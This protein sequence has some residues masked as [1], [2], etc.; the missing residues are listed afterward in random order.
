[1]SD[2]KKQ[3]H[4]ESY[5]SGAIIIKNYTDSLPEK[6]GVY[7]MI[8]I[9][10]KVLYVGKAKNLKARVLSY[11]RSTSLNNRIM[12][13]VSQ[14][15]SMIFERTASEAAAFLLEADLIKSLKPHFN[16]LLKDD[17]SYPY[18]L[19]RKDHEAPQILKHRGKKITKGIYW[20]PFASGGN[21]NRILETLQKV[22][23]LRTCTD[24]VYENRSR[25]CLLYQIKRCSAP[26]TGEI[27]LPEYEKTVQYAIDFMENGSKKII[28]SLTDDMY[29]ASENMDYEKAAEYR[30]RLKALSQIGLSSDFNP[31]TFSEADIFALFRQDGIVCIQANFM[32]SGQNWGGNAYFPKFQEDMTNS[33]IMDGFLGQFYQNKP[34]AK[35]ILISDA[36]SETDILIQALINR[37]DVK[38]SIEI[39]QKGEKKEAVNRIMLTAE[40]ELKRKIIDTGTQ[41]ELMQNL[42][43]MLDIDEKLTR[44]E[45][46]DNAH[47]Q[48]A[49]AVG[50]M[51][52]ATAE[53][54]A[55]KEYRTWKM[56]DINTQTNDDYAMM[57]EVFTRRFK[58]LQNE[59]LE[60]P[61]NVPSLII[62]DGGQGQL[63]TVLQVAN[64][65]NIIVPI[66]AVAKGQDR[67]AGRERFFLPNKPSF[68]LPPND[69]ILFYVQRLRDEAHRYANGMHQRKRDKPTESNEL[70]AITGIGA[71]RKKALI[72]H[73]GSSRAVREAT[74]EQLEKTPSIS[75]AIAQKIYAYFNDELD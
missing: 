6:P 13:M 29:Q 8:D 49:Y 50:A 39:P 4:S 37:Y 19:C 67:N 56:K 63:S 43:D 74:L 41:T 7:R 57:R 9:N 31:T 46:Y 27:S 52:V 16:V 1:M 12:R 75:K 64:L 51:I 68:I 72:A 33:D 73:F 34:P 69:K 59:S 14:T 21:V 10:N 70:D 38:V 11:T 48:G 45:V 17:K 18:I 58:S 71:G 47:I 23:L 66:I 36:I 3:F 30:D 61:Q 20:G 44:I 22:F 26:C 2:E 60:N 62:L 24:S 65:Y 25:P 5:E 55:K 28:K 42:A 35:L 53:G 54:F 15:H 32:R 40:Q